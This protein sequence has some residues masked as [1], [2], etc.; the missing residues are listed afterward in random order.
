[1]LTHLLR[2]DLSTGSLGWGRADYIINL[3]DVNIRNDSLRGHG[4]TLTE[5]EY[6]LKF[7]EHSPKLYKLIDDLGFLASYRLVKTALMEKRGDFFKISVQNL[8]GDNNTSQTI[9]CYWGLR[10]TPTKFFT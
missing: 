1:V 8:V 4:S 6:E 7:Q 3:V 9:T 10:S 5:A 2:A